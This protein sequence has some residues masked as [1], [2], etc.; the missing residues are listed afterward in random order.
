[1]VTLS[2]KFNDWRHKPLGGSHRAPGGN[3]MD[4]VRK[5]GA[6]V[7]WQEAGGLDFKGNGSAMRSGVVG[8]YYW[9]NPD[10]AFRIGALTSVCTHNNLEALLGAG[11]IAY[12][13]AACINHGDL[14]RAVADGLLLCSEF[15]RTVPFYPHRVKI[16]EKFN[17]QN[18]WYAV[19]RWGAAIALSRSGLDIPTCVGKLVDR[20]NI[21]VDGAVVPAVA[22]AIFFAAAGETFYDTVLNAVNNSDD[23]DTIGAMT[24]AIAGA[25]LG[26]GRI[27]NTWTGNIELANYLMEL[28]TN[29]YEASLQYT[30]SQEMDKV[31]ANELGS[32]VEDLP[33]GDE[34]F[35]IEFEAEADYNPNGK[36]C[37]HN[38]PEGKCSR[39]F[40]IEE[41]TA[42]IDDCESEEDNQEEPE[43]DIVLDDSSDLGGIDDEA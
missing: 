8:A 31:I 20:E 25:G 18:P 40:D 19:S 16:G 34:D 4:A 7:P 35:E 33:E 9:Q 17:E 2:S 22:S 39:C 23:T 13:V 5:L 11:M 43:D 32:S 10:Y 14:F 1:M 29:I 3:C 12:L 21:V 37:R 36:Y 28:G 15:E 30:A 24:G 38:M 27:P 26:Y 42:E 6:G 41:Q